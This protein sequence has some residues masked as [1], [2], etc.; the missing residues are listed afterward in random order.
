MADMGHIGIPILAGDVRLPGIDA[1]DH[2][3]I[4]E[5]YHAL[6]DPYERMSRDE[7]AASTDLLPLSVQIDVSLLRPSNE[8]SRS[9][10]D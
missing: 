6:H 9:G 3:S 4:E 5:R 8:S 2:L 7:F 1:G 10:P